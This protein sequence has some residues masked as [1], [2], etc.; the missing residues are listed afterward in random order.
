MSP[1]RTGLATLLASPGRC[2]APLLR[3]SCWRMN[4]GCGKVDLIAAAV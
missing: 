2:P 4:G 3:Q 1:H